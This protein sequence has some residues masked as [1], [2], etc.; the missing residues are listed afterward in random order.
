MCTKKNTSSGPYISNAECRKYVLKLQTSNYALCIYVLSSRDTYT[1]QGK[2]G[3]MVVY[4]LIINIYSYSNP[5]P[6]L[7]LY[8]H[9]LAN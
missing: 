5:F 9:A 7:Y 8:S 2:H 3:R 1:Q 6:L 4:Y